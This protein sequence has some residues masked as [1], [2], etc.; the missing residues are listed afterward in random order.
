MKLPLH[1]PVE[2]GDVEIMMEL[3]SCVFP[4]FSNGSG[5][6]LGVSLSEMLSSSIPLSSE[7]YLQEHITFETFSG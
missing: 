1:F 5:G 4:L 3:S 6:V 7:K 2:E